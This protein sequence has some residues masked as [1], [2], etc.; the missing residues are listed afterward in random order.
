[1][2][3]FQLWFG[4]SRLLNLSR[5]FFDQLVLSLSPDILEEFEYHINPVVQDIKPDSLASLPLYR[6]AGLLIPMQS[7]LSAILLLRIPLGTKGYHP[8]ILP[9]PADILTVLLPLI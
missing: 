5:L 8:L 9:T 6:A 7:A 2:L 1:M 3:A 4:I